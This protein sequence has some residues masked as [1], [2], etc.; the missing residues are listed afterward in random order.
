[1]FLL[2]S[3]YTIILVSSFIALVAISTKVQYLR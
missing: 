3:A 1:M 2:Y